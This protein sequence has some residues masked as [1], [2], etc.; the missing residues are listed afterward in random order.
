MIISNQSGGIVRGS[1]LECFKAFTDPPHPPPHPPPC[2]PSHSSPPVRP[3]F[4]TTA[5]FHPPSFISEAPNCPMAL[6]HHLELNQVPKYVHIQKETLEH[7]H[8]VGRRGYLVAA[9]RF[10]LELLMNPRLKLRIDGFC[11]ILNGLDTAEE[12]T[13]DFLLSIP[14]LLYFFQPLISHPTASLFRSHSPSLT[15]TG[16]AAERERERG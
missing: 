16:T 7:W 8:S 2:P 12:T 5:G 6:Q 14:F 15:P 13:R 11:P 3:S 1:P 4:T 9:S 10:L